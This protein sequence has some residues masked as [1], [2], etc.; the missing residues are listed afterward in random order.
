MT[1]KQ[2]IKYIKSLIPKMINNRLSDMHYG[3][4]KVIFKKYESEVDDKY[5]SGFTVSGKHLV[6]NIYLEKEIIPMLEKRILLDKI[7]KL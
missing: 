2:E 5:W 6:Y 7:K 4:T 3:E 1:P